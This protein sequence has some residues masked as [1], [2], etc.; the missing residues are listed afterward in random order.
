MFKRILVP[1]DGS[2]IAEQVFPFVA[3]LSAAFNS[4]V[5]CTG[6]CEPEESEYGHACQLYI[7]GQAELLKKKMSPD[8]KLK[9]VVLSGKAADEILSYATKNDV[10]LV[11][12][13]SHG[14]SG[15][16]P[17]SLGSTVEKVLHKVE[18]PLLIVRATEKSISP[19]ATGLFSRVLAPLDGSEPGEAALPYLTGLTKQL[20]SEIR[21]L[22]VLASG[23][24]VHTIG[25]I[26]YVYFKDQDINSTKTKAI[27]YLE[28]IASKLDGATAIKKCDVRFGDPAEEIV[29][30]AKETKA[31]LI[32]LSSHGHSG[33][34]RWAYGSVTYKVLQIT[35][36]SILL[37]PSAGVN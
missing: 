22:R 28:K 25:G 37:I 1:L 31:S 29:K 34:E 5:I 18:A 23:K 19:G 12:M 10:S 36:K 32:A 2:K 4:E 7:N 27:E 24:H 17:W 11:V 3:E 30:C 26:D 13:T 9:A 20:H 15:I 33:I 6:I 14:R 21:L 8:A 16:K 35:N